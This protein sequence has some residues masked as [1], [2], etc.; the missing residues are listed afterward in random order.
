VGSGL[1][2]GTVCVIG[3]MQPINL[4]PGLIFDGRSVVLGMA[5]VFGGPLV[6]AIAATIAATYRMSLGGAGAFVG[7]AVILT[8]VLFGLAYR[9]ALQRKMVSATP[10]GFLLLGVVMHVAALMW[11][12]LLPA[13]FALAVFGTL[14]FPYLV[15]LAPATAL[16]GILLQDL[17]QQ[18]RTRL[19]LISS[20]A[21]MRAITRASPDLL[22]VL[23]E[24]GRYLE[25]I[26]P[27]EPLPYADATK[28]VGRRMH[29][30]LPQAEADRF[31]AVIRRALDAGTPQ[32]I[33][34]ELDTRGGRH[35]FEGRAQALDTQLDGKGA[36]VLVARDI[37]DRLAAEQERRIA[38]IAFEAQ[39]GMIIADTD[40]VIL[41]VNKAFSQMT[42]Y[43]PADVI[44]RRTRMFRSGRQ[45][46]MFYRAMWDSINATGKWEGELWNRRKNGETFPLWMTITTVRNSRDVITHYVAALTDI[47]QRKSAEDEIRTLAFYDHLTALP[48][49]RLLMER[50]RQAL[51]TARRARQ[52]G[53]LM[54]IDLD[55]FKNINDRYGH[56]SGDLLL[57]EVAT[58]LGGAVRE[59]DTVARLGGDEFVI[60]L[61]H[62][63]RAPDQAAAEARKIA[64]KAL[65]ALAEPYALDGQMCHTSASIGIAMFSQHDTTVDA[66][67]RRADAAMYRAKHAGKNTVLFF[68]EPE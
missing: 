59:T 39:Q 23:D 27:E 7:V 15:V 19:A 66:L 54:F 65:E 34:F 3:M 4:A 50:L 17:E 41:R 49:R 28:I 12:T 8:S 46:C 33:E 9:H 43:A 68:A 30:V 45:D 64:G 29:E 47:T 6:G 48:N 53:A 11:F 42:G 57:Q 13:Q 24:D 21:H 26:S 38:A 18:T 31:L 51:A 63:H 56:H 60:M 16:L 44:G 40:T 32:V 10:L 25:V 67:M 61:E 22:L 52:C 58:R 1:I 55:D 5:G 20:E 37:S 62:L 14:A 2:F 36:V 35:V